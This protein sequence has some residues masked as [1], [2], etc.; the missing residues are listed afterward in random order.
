[1]IKKNNLIK[2]TK[3]RK[4]MMIILISLIL[5]F[6]SIILFWL[7]PGSPLKDKFK[8]LSKKDLIE[9]SQKYSFLSNQI[10]SEE[11]IKELPIA[12]Q[13][14]FRI[15]NLIGKPKIYVSHVVYKETNFKLSKDKPSL[16]IKYEHYNMLN[17]LNRIALID[18][19]LMGIPFDGLDRYE[20]GKGSMHGMF[21]KV[22]TVFNSTGEEMD[23]S[24]LVTCLS[25]LVFLPTIALEDYI[26]WETIDEN[27][28]KATINYNN[29]IVSAR[30]TTNSIGEIIKIETD[31]RYMDEGNGIST[32]YKWIINLTDYIE[33]NGIKHPSHAQ[34]IWKLPEEDYIYFD[35][36]GIT[37]QYNVPV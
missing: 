7:L 9:N 15:T 21:G 18:T 29:H 23:I 26:T 22:I 19:K 8:T 12:I 10:Y 33:E 1:M 35:G 34:A 4:V 27:N 37:I 24:S 31:D 25:E 11:D 30:F 16:R 5:I 6:G 2:N 17:H 28:A 3:G 36:K 13:K 32:K 20:N 14:F